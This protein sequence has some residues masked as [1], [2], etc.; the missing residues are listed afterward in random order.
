M[1]PGEEVQDVL[2]G[3]LVGRDMEKPQEYRVLQ[4]TAKRHFPE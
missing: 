3:G 1:F 2:S 4:L